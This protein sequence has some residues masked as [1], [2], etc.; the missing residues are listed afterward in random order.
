M[1]TPVTRALAFELAALTLLAAA[2][3][4]AIPLSTG[5]LAWSW[6]ALNHHIYLGLTAETPRWH[7]DVLPASFQTYQ[8]PYLYWPVY[9]LSL[10]DCC[11][12]QA[13]AL[14]S[15]LQAA[16]LLPPVW[17]VAHRLLPATGG[18]A[19]QGVLERLAACVLAFA[20]VVVLTG[21]ETTSNDLMAAVPLLWAVALSLR[22]PSHRRAF[23]AAALWGVATAF[24]LS[25]GLY[26]PLLL[27]W[28][29]LPTRPHLPWRR[30]MALAA[31]ALLG[32]GLTYAP[33]GWQL[34]Q[35]TGNPLHPFFG[36]WFGGG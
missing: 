4:A 1:R 7:L 31:G 12:A 30:A 8:Y 36:H 6:D 25:N 27:L 19:W 28:W 17:L 3:A 29:W 11:G 18:P 23:G 26:L 32:F 16:L 15:A 13:G 20:S 24:K 9:R 33:W 10:W 22:P 14:W 2:A 35:L 5:Y 34:W 21:L